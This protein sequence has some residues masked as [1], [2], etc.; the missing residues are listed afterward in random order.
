M[1]KLF[2]KT[3]IAAI[4]LGMGTSA[5]NEDSSTFSTEGLDISY[6][7]N[8]NTAITSFSIKANKKILTGLDSVFFTIDLN[9]FSIFNADSLPKGTDVSK[10]LVNIGNSGSSKIVIKYTDYKTQEKKEL[11]YSSSNNTDS[12]NF[13]DEVTVTVTSLNELQTKTY[14]IKVNV[15]KTEP[16]S[17]CWG[18]VQY[19]PLPSGGTPTA[20]G[21]AMMNEKLYCF[22]TDAGGNVYMATTD[23]PDKTESWA[24]QQLSMPF[25]PVLETLEATNSEL[26]MLADDGTL[27]SSADAVSWQSTGQK[28]ESTLGAINSTLTGIKQDN[29]KLFFACYPDKAG[30]NATEVPADFPVKGVSSMFV[31]KNKWSNEP[32]GV[33]TGGRCADGS[34]TAYTWGFDGKKWAKFGSLPE[35]KALENITIFPYFTF[36]T[37]N[38]TWQTTE[39]STL[40][41]LGGNEADGTIQRK[42]FISRDNGLNWHTGDNLLQLPSEMPSLTGAQAFVIKKE[43]SVNSRSI[44]SHCWKEIELKPLPAWYIVPDNTAASRAITPITQWDCPYIYMF[45]GYQQDGQLGNSIWR[46]VINRLTFKPLQ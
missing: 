37:D 16:D 26:Y 44:S 13:L 25:K 20:Q 7:T 1:K 40:F 15:H 17:L 39:Y 41:A 34:L 12:I 38:T 36:K 14:D 21:T 43:L 31:F 23:T 2:A 5:C 11:E 24:V 46:G 19:A 6:D 30:F 3:A 35:N 18:S 10:L 29:G 27:Y 42:V 33:I 45:G 9:K 32:Q 28:W 22:T 8:S 4:I